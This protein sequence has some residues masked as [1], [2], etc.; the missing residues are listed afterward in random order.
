MVSEGSLS[1]SKEPIICPCPEPDNST[2]P[3]SYFFNINFNIF[4]SLTPISLHGLSPSGLPT[5]ICMNASHLPYVPY[6]KLD[7]FDKMHINY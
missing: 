6:T 5:K 3:Q 1:C 7:V 2:P 4:L